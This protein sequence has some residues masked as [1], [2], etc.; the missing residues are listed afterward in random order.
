M[1]LHPHTPQAVAAIAKRLGRTADA[2]HWLTLAAKSGDTDAMFQL[3]RRYDHGDLQRC[4]TWLYR[5]KLVG[6]DLT[7][8][9]HYAVNE[10]GSDYD[11]QAA[12]ARRTVPY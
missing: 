4:W 6:A 2:R 3:I 8:D 7:R 11:D 5:A 9:A 12:V 10:D 1:E